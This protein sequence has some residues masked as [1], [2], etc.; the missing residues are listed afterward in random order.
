LSWVAANPVRNGGAKSVP[1][2]ASLACY[3]VQSPAGD[4]D[5]F[6]HQYSKS[7][8]GKAPFTGER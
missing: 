7:L 4:R 1:T 2:E 5:P 3:E 8:I 6:V